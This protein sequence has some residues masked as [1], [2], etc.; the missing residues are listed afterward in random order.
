MS[1]SAGRAL[2]RGTRGGE[3]E[4]SSTWSPSS[5]RR[6]KGPVGPPVSSSFAAVRSLCDSRTRL[7]T[8][9]TAFCSHGRSVAGP[10]GAPPGDRRRPGRPS[11]RRPAAAALCGQRQRR[12]GAGCS[13]LMNRHGGRRELRHGG[14]VTGSG[15][16]DPGT[17]ASRR[18]PD[19]RASRRVGLLDPGA[20]TPGWI[21]SRS[22]HWRS[23]RRRPPV[24]RRLSAPRS[25][26]RRD[27]GALGWAARVRA[28]ECCRSDRSL[29]E[30]SVAP[31]MRRFDPA[32]QVSWTS[33][34]VGAV[35]QAL[36]AAAGG[37]AF[38]GAAGTV[39]RFPRAPR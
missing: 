8:A 12:A 1:P 25:L 20:R 2:R 24:R 21:S 28:T 26:S 30:A 10:L 23:W 22:R 32:A 36:L 15:S 7:A 9:A 35:G 13:S 18:R 31:P 4:C 38:L 16:G 33:R 34:G 14:T 39:A 6:S 27:L 11:R 3:G 37:R 17:A 29:P 19:P 5:D